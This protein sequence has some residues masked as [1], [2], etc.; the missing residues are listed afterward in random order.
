MLPMK[1]ILLLAMCA[2]GIPLES[3]SGSADPAEKMVGQI[4]RMPEDQRPPDWSE[5][6]SLMARRPP[7]VGEMAPD[8]TLK[9]HDGKGSITRSAFHEG[10]PL[11]LVFGSYT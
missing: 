8:F 2:A 3:G 1:W 10:R 6:K 11:V 9:T 5:T 4:D 7:A